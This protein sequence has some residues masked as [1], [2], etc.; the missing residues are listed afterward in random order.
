MDRRRFVLAWGRKMFFGLSWPIMSLIGLV[1]LQSFIFPD[2]FMGWAYF[3]FTFVGQYGL[4]TALLYF[5]GFYPIVSLSPTYYVSRVW[6]GTLII[7]SNLLVLFDALVFY[8]YRIH[9]N[10]LMLEFLMKGGFKQ[11]MAASDATYIML[12][13][14]AFGAFTGIWVWGNSTWKT[15]RGRF[16]NPVSN[17]YLAVIAISMLVSH[18][19][20]LLADARGNGSVTRLSVLFPVNFA[21]TAKS[22]MH[23]P[24]YVAGDANLSE[25][26]RNQIFY[27]SREVRCGGT[28][29]K[30]ILF[31][32]VNN[33]NGE[34]FNEELTPNMHHYASHGVRF[35]SHFGAG[36]T[37]E[38]G[39]FSLLYS[40]PSTYQK[41]V[42]EAGI[43]SV[44]MNEL[45]RR[46][47]AIKQQLREGDTADERA[48]NTNTDW[49]DWTADLKSAGQT[50]PFFALLQYDLA[51]PANRQDAI[52]AVDKYAGEIILDL[53]KKGLMDQT[54]VVMTA[55][56]G[57]GANSSISAKLETPMAMVWPGRKADVVN[58]VTS[59]YDVVPTI[60]KDLWRCQ[61][62]IADYSF[63]SSLFDS[64]SR[65]WLVAGN[66]ANLNI[67]DFNNQL[68]TTIES[69][70]SYEV[71]DF[72]L[73]KV[74][75]L[76]ASDTGFFA[77]LRDLNRFHRRK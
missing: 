1:Y 11:V 22:L 3:L 71:R 38:E 46:N 45:A 73:N 8:Q 74:S 41:P 60:M 18:G 9:L 39:I 69:M 61:N 63:G 27:P 31:I 51:S 35:N 28:Q 29:E 37:M 19:I 33:L 77:I 68:V 15:M 34:E 70:R 53:Y 17:F 21:T 40:L 54:I 25:V 16:S 58:H 72:S 20:H 10:G 55:A 57:A 76:K 23:G 13:V 7:T 44:F 2:S 47:F 24:D 48:R 66:S 5:F 56:R 36:E 43:Q 6:A 65:K 52:R 26:R 50:Q 12:A 4:L 32:V 14:V 62:A 75:K 67:L 49:K 64:A 42:T 59:H 30:N